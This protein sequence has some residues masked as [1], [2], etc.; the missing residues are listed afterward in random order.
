MPQL[1][2]AA[3]QLT[4][5]LT[6][7]TPPLLGAFLPAGFPDQISCVDLL[8]GLVQHGADILEV[9]VPVSHPA[10]D[11]PAITAAYR[12]ALAQNTRMQHVLTTVRH[13]AEAGA[14]V[15]VMSYWQAVLDHGV[16]RFAHELAEAGAAGAMIPDLHLNHAATW[17]E[18]ARSAG[19]HTP[20][21]APRTADDAQ[22][23]RIADVA[24]GWIYAPAAHS[25]TGYEGV[26]DVGAFGRFTARLR[27]RTRH[28]VV[29]GI[30]IST[31][32]HASQIAPYTEG[33]VVGTPLVRPLLTQPRPEGA[34]RTKALAAA[35][36]Q[37]LRDPAE[38][39]AA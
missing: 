36:A 30:G 31:P 19:I 39:R 2:D 38:P 34:A 7:A 5:H 33:V 24:S 15:V 12:Q 14:P 3:T 9:G 32:A 8:H 1:A 21:F 10:L 20:Q 18:A 4:R 26:L 6:D 27:A 13:A 35:F 25:A 17:L 11:G 37:A 22:L 16:Q 23:A 28:P 29:A